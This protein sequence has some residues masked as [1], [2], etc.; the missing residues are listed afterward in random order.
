MTETWITVDVTIL[1][2][3][4]VLSLIAFVLDLQLFARLVQH[5]LL[6][7]SRF[8]AAPVAHLSDLSF[9]GQGAFP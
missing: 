9:E 5:V 7:L 3:L 2:D 6:D 8:R 1:L 4:L